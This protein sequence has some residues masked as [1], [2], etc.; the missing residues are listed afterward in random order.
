MIV[1]RRRKV[2]CSILAYSGSCYIHAPFLSQSPNPRPCALAHVVQIRARPATPS[3][4]G[5]ARRQTGVVAG[6]KKQAQLPSIACLWRPSPASRRVERIDIARRSSPGL[7]ATGR[8]SSRMRVSLLTRCLGPRPPL[9]PGERVDHGRAKARSNPSW[10][11][12]MYS[13]IRA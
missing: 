7:A 2:A 5:T 13:R 1:R 9:S 12:S 8:C 6:L 4:V 11:G 3:R 10:H